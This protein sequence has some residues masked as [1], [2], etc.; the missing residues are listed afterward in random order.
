M[1][2]VIF[3]LR[4][5]DI[6][7][8]GRSDIIFAFEL[9]TREAHITSEG[10]ITHLCIELAAGEYN[11]KTPSCEQ[12]GVFL[13]YSPAASSMHRCVILPSAVICASR[14]GSYKANIISL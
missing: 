9:L 12:D 13:L 4:K 14:V 8:V 6:A 11:R 7:P 3:L 2:S 5:S 10:H 1:L